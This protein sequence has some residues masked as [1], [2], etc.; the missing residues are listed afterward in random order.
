M[1]LATDEI[2][3]EQN[4]RFYQINNYN[5]DHYDEK[6]MKN[7]FNSDDDTFLWKSLEVYN[8]IKIF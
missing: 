5:S 6:Y 2:I 3:I 1:L 4:Q 8:M 7:K